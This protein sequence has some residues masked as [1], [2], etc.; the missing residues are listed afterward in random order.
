MFVDKDLLEKGRIMLGPVTILLFE[1]GRARGLG[2]L[3]NRWRRK[4]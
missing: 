2:V 4:A 1:R 3:G